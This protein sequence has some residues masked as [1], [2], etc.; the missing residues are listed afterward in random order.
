MYTFIRTYLISYQIKILLS[1][2]SS[3]T[4]YI[5]LKESHEKE[6]IRL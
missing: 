2:I 6:I 4:K 1:N 5:D 3:F